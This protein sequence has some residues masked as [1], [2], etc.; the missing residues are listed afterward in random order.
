MKL[1]LHNMTR[2]IICLIPCLSTELTY[3]CETQIESCPNPGDLRGILF[4]RIGE[5]QEED[6]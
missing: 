3:Y 4:K 6:T 5:L 1:Q 2:V